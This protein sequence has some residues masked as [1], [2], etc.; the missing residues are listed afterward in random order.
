MSYPARAEGL[1]NMIRNKY[2]LTLIN[3]FDALQG[4]TET[5]ALNEEYENFVNAH[6]KAGNAYQLNKELNLESYGR[7]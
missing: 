2:A 5:H 7:H 4:K 1:V 6:I 3:K